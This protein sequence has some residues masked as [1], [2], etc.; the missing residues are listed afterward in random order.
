MTQ[1]QTPSATGK[2]APATTGLGTGLGHRDRPIRPRDPLR[3]YATRAVLW[4]VIAVI[5]ASVIGYVLRWTIPYNVDLNDP[6]YL[7]LAVIV[8]LAWMTAL[9]MRGAYDTRILGVGSEEFKRVIAATAT[10]FSAV[11]IVV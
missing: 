5:T 7:S 11:A 8:V 6:T 10:V 2:A 3:V 4:D 1:Q 9:V